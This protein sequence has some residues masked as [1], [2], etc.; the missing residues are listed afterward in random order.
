MV[1]GKE[2]GPCPEIGGQVFARLAHAVGHG[3]RMRPNGG[4]SRNRLTALSSP[5]CR[6]VSPGNRLRRRL[7]TA[8]P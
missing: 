4:R 5:K 1:P 7:Q 6:P 8:G 2:F 3:Q